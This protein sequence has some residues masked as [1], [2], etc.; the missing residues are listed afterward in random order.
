MRYQCLM[1]DI[2]WSHYVNKSI[3][4]PFY[5]NRVRKKLLTDNGR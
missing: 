4:E 2:N 1:R 5:D 3:Q